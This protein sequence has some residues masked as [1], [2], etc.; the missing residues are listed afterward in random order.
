MSDDPL[1]TLLDELLGA[2]DGL[3]DG[4]R[5]GES[6]RGRSEE[7]PE[8]PRRALARRWRVAV[9]VGA[10][11]MIASISVAA[12]LVVETRTSAPLSGRLPRELLGVRY[13]LQIG[14]DLMAGQAGWCATLSELGS[15]QPVSLNTESCDTSQGSVIAQGGLVA[16]SA[17][18]G[19]VSGWLLYAVV[20]QRVAVLLAP[21]GTRIFP[22]HQPQLPAGW[23]AAVTIQ[24]NPEKPHGTS[25]M[26][27]LRP[28]SERGV[29]LPAADLPP[30]QATQPPV[31]SVNASHPPSTGCAI[32]GG[33]VPGIRLQSARVL[34]GVAPTKPA[35]VEPDFLSCYSLTFDVHGQPGVAALL[36][37]ARHPGRSPQEL[38]NTRPLP[39][40]PG[41]VSGPA[42]ENLGFGY[43]PGARLSAERIP[44]GWLVVQTAA[45]R[46]L[47]PAGIRSFRVRT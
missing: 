27:T 12:A 19:A 11:T 13:D 34:R 2:H 16:V 26:A 18:S 30:T 5:R 3:A 20:D 40:E 47:T 14:P 37:D 43:M 38:P 41:I 36:L 32:D 31:R 39:H 10:L 23:T 28:L 42:A 9:L 22:I 29:A 8:P 4:S 46:I 25:T 1:K 21:D 15:H 33:A 45:S 6:S 17:A 7:G 35:E 24:A 44:G